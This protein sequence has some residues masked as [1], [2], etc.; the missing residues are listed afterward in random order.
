[1]SYSLSKFFP[2]DHNLT[3]PSICP[4]KKLLFL[5]IIDKQL[6]GIFAL[7]S[8]INFKFLKSHSL[9]KWSFDPDNPF[10]WFNKHLTQVIS[11]LCPLK[12]FINLLFFILNNFTV[13]SIEPVKINSSLLSK[14]ASVIF[15]FIFENVN[16]SLF[17]EV[18]Y[19]FIILS[20]PV[21]KKVCP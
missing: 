10:S 3:V 9:I 13:L 16:I 17:F 1:M 7:W 6:Q 5:L 19:N 14:H 4:L 12:I 11:L 15:V 8:F 21:V 18:S 2:L 20:P